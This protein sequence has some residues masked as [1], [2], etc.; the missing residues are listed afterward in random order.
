[1]NRAAHLRS[2]EQALSTVR[3]SADRGEAQVGVEASG[4]LPLVT[5][6]VSPDA[7]ATRSAVALW[8]RRNLARPL[9]VCAGSVNAKATRGRDFQ[10]VTSARDAGVGPRQAARVACQSTSPNSPANAAAAL[11]SHS[12][13]GRNLEMGRRCYLCGGEKRFS[14]WAHTATPEAHARH[15]G[16]GPTTSNQVSGG[17]GPKVAADNA[18]ASSA[19]VIVSSGATDC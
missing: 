19:R 12:E 10:W 15:P 8:V 3:G 5:T 9:E 14:G 1:M 4:G 13:L 18:W 16:R 2:M 17:A 6:R 11:M 7:P